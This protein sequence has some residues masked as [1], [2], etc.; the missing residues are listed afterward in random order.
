MD[1]KLAAVALTVGAGLVGVVRPLGARALSSLGRGLPARSPQAMVRNQ[2]GGD[3]H[4]QKEL[5]SSSPSFVSDAMK[6]EP[7]K[8][9]LPQLAEVLP[10]AFV[11][12]T[13]AE[14][15]LHAAKNEKTA[16]D[17]V[18]DVLKAKP[19]EV[20]TPQLAEIVPNAFVRTPA[21]QLGH[22]AKHVMDSAPRAPTMM[23][24]G[25]IKDALTPAPRARTRNLSTDSPMAAVTLDDVTDR[26]TG[27]ITP[28]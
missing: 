10:S 28:Q 1:A 23:S 15:V 4:Q 12:R 7:V 21:E 19:L 2:L 11:Q 22:D 16:G 3:G 8:P 18:P 6:V 9:H 5:S 24:A 25:D 17:Y 20:H 26:V 14:E 13:P 27:R